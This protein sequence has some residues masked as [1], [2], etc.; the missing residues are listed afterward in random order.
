[1]IDFGRDRIIVH[2]SRAAD[3]LLHWRQKQEPESDTVELL[4]ELTWGNAMEDAFML[5]QADVRSRVAGSCTLP[6]GLSNRWVRKGRV[7]GWQ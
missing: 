3:P 1:M 5:S 6:R 2:G 7:S 4:V